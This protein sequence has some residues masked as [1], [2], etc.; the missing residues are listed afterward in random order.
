[1]TT[2]VDVAVEFLYAVAGDG[3]VVA[4]QYAG[5]DAGLGA[6][7]RMRIDPGVLT[8]LPRSLQEQPL[9]R[10]HRHRFTRRN[11]KELRIELGRVIQKR[12]LT[13]ITTPR[14]IRIR[15]EKTLKIPTPIHRKTTNS[16][17][18]LNHQIPQPTRRHHTTRKTTPHTHNR[19]RLMPFELNLAQALAS[20][21][22]VRGYPLEV[23][24]KLFLVRHYGGLSGVI[25][26]V[27]DEIEDLVVRRG[28]DLRGDIVW[29]V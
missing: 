22:E 2:D 29:R 13:H 11:P 4:V 23:F 27:V 17:P 16:I 8:R 21:V 9:L 24:T 20:L 26:L 28:F 10:I 5:E 3:V 6:A 12:A 1:V 14:H 15:I 18:P 19:N 25:Q 7:Q